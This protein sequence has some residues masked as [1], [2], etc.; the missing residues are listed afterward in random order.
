MF[1]KKCPT[2]TSSSNNK[3][4]ARMNRQQKLVLFFTTL[5]FAVTLSPLISA[6]NQK[7]LKR[8][9]GLKYESNTFIIM[10]CMEKMLFV[11][12]TGNR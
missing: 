8:K 11:Y 10:F 2:I 1:Q 6:L 5:K 4:S 9:V 12:Q 7:L 3:L